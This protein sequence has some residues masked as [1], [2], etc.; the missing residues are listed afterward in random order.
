MRPAMQVT[1]TKPISPSKI[2]LFQSCKL[3]YLAES[4]GSV[5][6]RL[7]A[8]PTANL[9]TA[10]HATIEALIEKEIPDIAIIKATLV[11]SL[12]GQ[13][14]I[15]D[16]CSPVTHTAFER[17]GLRGVTS[18][19]RILQLCGYITEVLGRLPRHL[20]PGRQVGQGGMKSQNQLGIEK[21]ASSESLEMAGRI[22]Y[23][24]LDSSE[25]VLHVVDFKTGSVT[26]ASNK[27]KMEY[28]LQIA[29]YGLMLGE[30]NNISKVRLHLDGPSGNWEGDLTSELENRVRYATR[31][32]NRSLPVGKPFIAQ[33]IATPGDY[34]RSCSVRPSCARYLSFL[35]ADDGA[36]FVPLGDIRGI[37]IGLRASD[38]L[39]KVQIENQGK[40]SFTVT[41]IPEPMWDK[42]VGEEVSMYGLHTNEPIGRGRYVANFYVIN[43]NL[44]QASAFGF[45]IE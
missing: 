31:E 12:K 17:Y 18:Q 36:G 42:R 30:A 7:P 5:K 32:I 9:G 6:N 8:G 14:S 15:Q 3:K 23:S 40:K 2:G 11:D 24:Y 13:F 4:E 19:A 38:S 29:A 33:D 43:A 39:V 34:C 28:L 44:P 37:V 16:K 45:L 22:D 20:G 1:R 27:P 21:W 26:D 10:V 35:S 41:G 25:G